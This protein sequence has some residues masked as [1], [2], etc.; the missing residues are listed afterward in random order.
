MGLVFWGDDLDGVGSHHGAN[1][2]PN[3]THFENAA[4]K[5]TH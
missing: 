4:Q 3:Y 5:H 2:A 1:N